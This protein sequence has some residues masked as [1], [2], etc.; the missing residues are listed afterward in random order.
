MGTVAD[1]RT[2]SLNIN[3]TITR[4]HRR[5]IA[6]LAVGIGMADLIPVAHAIRTLA[7]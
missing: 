3:A 1:I 2:A 7:L 4:R 6:R 5:I